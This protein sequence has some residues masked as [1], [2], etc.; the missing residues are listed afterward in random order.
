V[1]QK[2]LDPQRKRV[3]IAAIS[4]ITIVA[5]LTACSGSKH[6]KKSSTPSSTPAAASTSDSADAAKVRQVYTRFVDPKVPVAQK[7]TLIQDGAAFLPAMTAASTSQYANTVSLAITSVT[8][9]SP[10]RATVIFNVLLSGSPVVT[11]Q[12]GYAIN[13]G[14]QW[15]VAGVTFCG[16]LAAQGT[17]PAVCKTAAATSLPD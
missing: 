17:A 12:T 2:Q 9:S 3:A 8:V 5:A 10:K 4:L 14:G 6:P 7:V 15:K 11:N 13:E 16:L 1:R